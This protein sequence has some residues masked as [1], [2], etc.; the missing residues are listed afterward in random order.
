VIHQCIMTN[1]LRQAPGDQG[2]Q[3]LTPKGDARLGNN[4]RRTSIVLVLL[5]LGGVLVTWISLPGH[6]SAG[7]LWALACLALGS[8]AG[9]LFA[10]PRVAKRKPSAGEEEN[11]EPSASERG[12]GL[13]INTNLEEIS[14]WL[15]KIL[16]GLGLVELR[17]LPTYIERAGYYVAQGIGAKEQSVAS[18]LIL[19]FLGLGFL[20]GYLLT[21]M[22]IGPAFRL[23]DEATAVGLKEEA[24]KIAEN[25]QIQSLATIDLYDALDAAYGR[26]MDYKQRGESMPKDV[27]GNYIAELEN[28]RKDP[29]WAINRRLHLLLGS[30]YRR[31]GRLEPAIAVLTEFIDRKKEV[32]QLDIHRADGLYNRACYYTLQYAENPQNTDCA[33]KALADLKQSVAV[34]PSNASDAAHDKDFSTLWDDPR[35]KSITKT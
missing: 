6:V 4:L 11:S 20:S 10:I 32:G 33:D 25:A 34:A 8:I 30:L 23:A 5:F 17:S 27:A 7:L 31:T 26:V 24:V 15:T 9:F 13:G 3:G 1:S 21:R 2:A 18:G 35:F 22:F 14:D 19:Y 16:V 29:R 28:F 12:F